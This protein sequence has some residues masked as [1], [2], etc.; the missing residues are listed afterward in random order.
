MDNPLFPV[1]FPIR[2]DLIRPEHFR[3]AVDAAIARARVQLDEIESGSVPPE[4]FMERFEALA[5]DA[6]D[7]I[8]VVSHLESVVTSPELRAAL[9]DVQ[10]D[11]TEFSTSITFS[12]RAWDAVKSFAS[13]PFASSLAGP[14]R[15]WRDDLVRAFR[16]SGADLPRAG[17][18]RLS[19]VH[20]RLAELG[21]RFSQNVLDSTNAFEWFATDAAQIA[22]IPPAERE[23]AAERAAARGRPGWMFGLHA[24]HVDSVMRYAEDQSVREA[25]YMAYW[26][27]AS[28]G[29]TDN[30]PVL[31]EMLEL[32][33]EMAVMLGYADF[34]DFVTEDRMAGSGWRARDFI[35]GLTDMCVGPAGDQYAEL[36][37]FAGRRLKPW[38]VPYF[39]EKMVQ[40]T[41]GFDDE[42]LRPYLELEACLSGVLGVMSALH[43][44]SFEPASLPVWH[45]S[46]RS[47]R[48]TRGGSD[49]GWFYLD[50]FMRD[51]K[52]SG[53]WMNSFSSRPPV[54]FVCTNFQPPAAGKPALITH[55]NLVT[56]FH[57]FGHLMHHLLCRVD[58]ESMFGTNVAWD[59]VELPSQIMENWCWERECL[60]GFAAHHATGDRIPEAMWSSLMASRRF[61][62]AY[63]MLRYLAFSEED[64]ALHM[65]WDPS[66]G[67]D[68]VDTARAATARF[69]FCDPVD[70]VSHARVFDHIFSDSVGYAS[71]YYS[72]KWAEVLDADAFRR[73]REAGIFDPETSRRFRESILEKG[74]TEDANDMFRA[75]MGRDPD[76]SA[77]FERYGLGQAP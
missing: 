20:V 9:A 68:P 23:R 36:E 54:G 19:A 67:A 52:A 28:S 6:S 51:T 26:T 12:L 66:S 43:G 47:Y 29:P 64:L 39:L 33:R 17:R 18:D 56:L 7:I 45:Q 71:G 16:T 21:T 74:D 27:R 61:M 65:D 60:D 62:G 40:Q 8:G 37:R 30:G 46:V 31:K 75:F 77:L 5:K 50:P 69:S 35:S 42:A 15:K 63:S 70:G 73:F 3:P 48:V 11:V 58:I 22:G 32:R 2:F 13:S 49:V 10:P 59:F 14:A 25:F 44:V 76:P 53:A 72:Y 4:L 57:E 34:A 38:D 1:T 41:V 55:E 24:P